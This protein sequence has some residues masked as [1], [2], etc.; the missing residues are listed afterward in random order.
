MNTELTTGIVRILRSNGQTVGTGF[1]LT[2]DGL[3]V[4]CAHVVRLAGIEP[5]YFVHMAFHFS[6]EMEEAQVLPEF[7]REP[8]AE[9]IAI[10]CLKKSLPNGVKPLELGSESGTEQHPFKTFGFP[11]SK[12]LDGMF[13]YGQIGNLTREK[14]HP[15]LQL[16]ETT[17]VTSGFSGAPV[18]DQKTRRIVGMVTSI[19]APDK[20]GRLLQTAFITPASTLKAVCP[21]L[22]ISDICPYRG[23]SAFTEDQ[24]EFFYGRQ[25]AVEKLLEKLKQEPPFL[26]VLGPSGSGKSSLVQAG[27]IPQLKKRNL[28]GSDRWG[29]LITSPKEDPFKELTRIGLLNADKDLPTAVQNWLENNLQQTRL[30]LVLDQFEEILVSCSEESRQKFFL[31]LS[32][33]SE[34]DFPISVIFVMRNDFYSRLA[35]Q[36][37]ELMEWLQ[38]GNLYNVP[39]VIDKDDLKSIVLRPAEDVG[40]RF[41][42]GLIEDLI[43]D[44]IK[45]NPETK[46]E[47]VGS[48]STTLPLLEFA[49]KQLWQERQE[50]VMTHK[51]YQMIGRVTG[52]LAK[53]ANDAFKELENQKLSLLVPR[54][55]TDLVHLGNPSEGVPDT[56]RRRQ[57]IELYRGDKSQQKEVIEVVKILAD[58]RLL[59]TDSNPE[60]NQNA[61]VDIIHDALLQ[62]WDKLKEWLRA[63]SSF[64][65]WYQRIEEQAKKWE[66]TDRGISQRDKERLLRGRILSE[67][68]GWHVRR[69]SDLKPLVKLFIQASLNQRQQDENRRRKQRRLLIGGLSIGLALMTTIAGFALTQLQTAERRRMNQY[70]AIANAL[71]SNSQFPESLIY[72]VVAIGLGRSTFVRFPQ[73]LETNLLSESILAKPI[74]AIPPHYPIPYGLPCH[75]FDGNADEAVATFNSDKSLM[76]INESSNPSLIHLF[77]LTD[78]NGRS[79]SFATENA[80]SHAIFSPNDESILSIERNGPIRIWLPS[81]LKA[82]MSSKDSDVIQGPQNSI[83]AVAFSPDGEII[84]Y[85]GEDGTIS[86]WSPNGNSIV[87]PFHGHLARI[88]TVAFSPDGKS[89]ISGS[90]DG[91][92]RIWDPK[93]EPISEPFGD[94]GELVTSVAFSPNS[95]LIGSG[96]GDGTVRLWDLKGNP[97][98]QPFRGHT[99]RV[100]SVAF[101]ADGKSIASGSWDRSVRVWDLQGNSVTPP[102]YGHRERVTSVTFSHDGLHIISMG[103]GGSG[104]LWNLKNNSS[105][106]RPFQAHGAWV[107]SV[108]FS[109]DGQFIASGSGDRTIRLW[110][111]NGNPVGQPFRGHTDE[112]TSVAFS[113]DGQLI[114]S[115]SRDHTV[116]LWDLDGN[117]IGQPFRGHEEVVES[118]AFSPDGQLIAS[119]S[120]DETV[121][122]WTLQGNP[123]A[124]PFRGH[125][126]S[127]NSVAF[128]PD[129]Q[130]IASSDTDQIRLWDR[131]GRSVGQPFQDDRCS[132]IFSV[133]FSPDG[134][135]IASSCH[136][137]GVSIWKPV[138][139][140]G[141]WDLNGNLVRLIGQRGEKRDDN[142]I[143]ISVAFSPDSKHIAAADYSGL[144]RVWDLTGNLIGKPIHGHLARVNSVAFSPNGQLIASG[145]SDRTVRLWSWPWPGW[146]PL[147][148][149]RIRNGSVAFSLLPGAPHNEVFRESIETCDRYVQ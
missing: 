135:Y 47:K 57:L 44:L 108:A 33:L 106:G 98:G 120:W 83:S 36:A 111:M 2:A 49:L 121:R 10:L 54:I 43:D 133:A 79:I 144:I 123:I 81:R 68:E 112:V 41:E 103:H 143:V 134:Q 140:V 75:R 146:L 63:D 38:E 99:D 72:G 126:E 35:Q 16:S 48:L 145:S 142:E 7:W 91:N 22:N 26:A 4:T 138:A 88:N 45:A 117:F 74:Q 58:K 18:W 59:A 107:G 25:K 32:R 110:H 27:V 82:F 6:G 78:L 97:V 132:N 90:D 5:G 51:A 61:N 118:V 73:L 77:C 42:E 92:L 94:Y 137:H 60:D 13:G 115:S 20:F 119:G 122:V 69:K 116:R 14:G 76:I 55:F 80:I 86:I 24:A 113:P 96:S 109:P 129:G 148:C 8:D 65:E 95:R 30:V 136:D 31:Q 67:A 102:F 93:G 87:K 11:E 70:V 101:S 39:S 147:A 89:I 71:Q 127:I 139:T 19:L 124:P 34:S 17:E 84:V 46:I 1:V 37:P 131:Q 56:K 85:G 66:E 9:D 50:G 104:R 28:P 141:L 100:T 21:R 64:L 105:I 125:T 114:A 23:L 52:S 149:E 29:I 3:V 53:W 130:R 12:S 128:S 62:Q 40:L 15:V